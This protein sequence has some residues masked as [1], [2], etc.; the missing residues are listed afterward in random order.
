M[1]LTIYGKKLGV[2]M[3]TKEIQGKQRIIYY[4]GNM[5]G[6]YDFYEHT[7]PHTDGFHTHHNP[8]HF[9]IIYTASRM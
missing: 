4:Q 3:K 8:Q 7:F 5:V 6:R 2:V 9:G 1:W